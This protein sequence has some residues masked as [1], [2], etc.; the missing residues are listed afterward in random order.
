MTVFRVQT[1]WKSRDF[2]HVSNSSGVKLDNIT[3]T[4]FYEQK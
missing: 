4:N 3:Y 2:W 1:N